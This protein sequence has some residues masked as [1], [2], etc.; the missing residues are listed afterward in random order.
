MLCFKLEEGKATLLILIVTMA[1]A[2]IF[3][4]FM[5]SY[6]SAQTGY[7]ELANKLVQDNKALVEGYQQN[8]K[9][10]WVEDAVRQS[11]D[12]RQQVRT[13]LGQENSSSSDE[14]SIE[15]GKGIFLFVSSSVPIQELR[16]YGKQMEYSG[17]G[18][19][20]M[21]GCIDGCKEIGPT[22]EWANQFLKREAHCKGAQCEVWRN[23]E[24]LID[25]VLFEGYQVDKVPAFVFDDR[26]PQ[27]CNEDKNSYRP[28][29][30]IYGLAPIR[31][32][33]EEARSLGYL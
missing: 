8:N 22:L 5:V 10:D 1:G 27:H 21:N 23:V 2:L 19:F 3:Q 11:E 29:E 13:I 25:P 17:G 28:K 24:L 15:K 9:L 12:Y 31:S 32:A 26:Q 18:Y 7:E 4:L 20:V 14:K 16:N 30:V 6:V 33:R